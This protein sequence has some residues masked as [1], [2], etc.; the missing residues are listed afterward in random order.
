VFV[1]TSPHLRA[2]IMLRTFARFW[3]YDKNYLR[4]EPNGFGIW[5][6]SHPDHGFDDLSALHA[7]VYRQIRA[8]CILLEAKVA[9]TKPLRDMGYKRNVPPSNSDVPLP[10]LGYSIVE[11]ADRHRVERLPLGL[12]IPS[13]RRRPRLH[14]R[15]AHWRHFANHRTRI[16]WTLAG[17]PDLGFVEKE[18]RL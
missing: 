17:N 13:T 14:F 7:L 9:E 18:Y 16:P 5:A 2:L 1:S 4:F 8:A 12:I 3:T 11:L 6:T 10:K 15:C